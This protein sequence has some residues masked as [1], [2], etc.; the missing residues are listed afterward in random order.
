MA[1]KKT[2]LVSITIDAT[3]DALARILSGAIKGVS[4]TAIAGKPVS[5]STATPDKPARVYDDTTCTRI[6]APTLI[7]S[8]AAMRGPGMLARVRSVYALD[9]PTASALVA[10]V[11]S[12]LKDARTYLYALP[13]YADRFAALASSNI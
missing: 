1:A 12:A 10:A 2:A 6:E 8:I 5:L 9:F 11:Q 7:E 4:L 13:Q 3:P